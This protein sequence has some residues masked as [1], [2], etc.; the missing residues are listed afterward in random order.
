M[1]T[2]NI[3]RAVF[4]LFF[5][6]LAFLACAGFFATTACESDDPEPTPG[7]DCGD[8]CIRL[9]A[10]A[11]DNDFYDQFESDNDCAAEC[12]EIEGDG[13]TQCMID[14]AQTGQ[15]CDVFLDCVG[16]C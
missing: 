8:L 2:E 15:D 16:D 11:D 10:C 5:A 1:T 13:T 4:R 9:Q 7:S 12:E 14:C 3:R 6:A